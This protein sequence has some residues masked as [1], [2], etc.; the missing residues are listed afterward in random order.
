V[1]DLIVF[2]TWSGNTKKIAR[3]IQGMTGGELLEIL[4]VNPY[5]K[6]YGPC[7]EQAKG[8]IRSGF[9]PEIQE[10]PRDLSDYDRIF[11]GSPIWWGTMAPPLAAFLSRSDLS[12][13]RIIPFCTHGGG[14]QGRFTDDI[15]ES[16]P[17]GEIAGE[18]VIFGNG[19]RSLEAMVRD[20][21]DRV[22]G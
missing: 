6:R 16:R 4:P 3:T 15:R 8:E 5:P 20:W 11:F 2:Y 13:K 19:G 9:Q 17:D 10:I 1:G 12:G 22:K 18:L 14:G 21:L 7:A